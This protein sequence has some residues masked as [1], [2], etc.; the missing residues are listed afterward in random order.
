MTNWRPEFD[1][2]DLYFITTKAVDHVHLFQRNSVKRLLVDALDCLHLRG[3]L[4]LYAFVIMP[5]HIHLI[6]KCP[7]EKPV[8]DL[9]RVYKRHVAER[10]IRQYQ[11][12]NNQ[13]ALNLLAT[14]VARPGRQAYKVWEDGYSAKNVFS[15]GFLRQKMEYIHSNPCQPQWGLVTDPA[16]YIWSSARFYLTDQPSIIPVK[17]ARGLMV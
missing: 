4:T 1:P 16:E 14:K 12:E 11:V 7:A 15:P 8:N 3:W 5:N 13:Q 9:V 6:T 2:D 17:D 10:L